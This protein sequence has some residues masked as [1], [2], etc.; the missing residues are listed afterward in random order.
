MCVCVCMSQD[1][2]SRVEVKGRI[3]SEFRICSTMWCTHQWISESNNCHFPLKKCFK[4]RETVSCNMTFQN[5]CNSDY[6]LLPTVHVVYSVVY[7]W[8]NWRRGSA[9]GLG[10]V[11]ERS[12]SDTLCHVLSS[13][14]KK[15]ERSKT[16]KKHN[17]SQ[18]LVANEKERREKGE[19]RVICSRRRDS[20]V[21]NEFSPS[22]VCFKHM[23]VLVCGF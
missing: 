11:I 15:N 23:L 3:Q 9:T 16:T 14:E 17:A 13:R 20:S 4:C 18:S 6:I 1:W 8:S 10:C 19:E 5:A 2:I 21:R 12:V 7:S 22:T